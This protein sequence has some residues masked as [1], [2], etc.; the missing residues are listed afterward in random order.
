MNPQENRPDLHGSERK[1]SRNESLLDQPFR[2]NPSFDRA[3][4][5]RLDAARF[6]LEEEPDPGAPTALLLAY[7]AHLEKGVPNAH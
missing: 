4:S 6:L 1:L 2:V 3:L 7:L 5:R